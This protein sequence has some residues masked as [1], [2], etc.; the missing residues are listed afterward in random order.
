MTCQEFNHVLQDYLDGTL[1]AIVRADAERHLRHCANCRA[2]MLREEAVGDALRHSL[3]RVT[4][5]LSLPPDARRTIEQALKG[6]PS[7]LSLPS[8]WVR[9]W[10]WLAS[11]SVLSVGW[12]AAGLAVAVLVLG[13]L[14]YRPASKSSAPQAARGD[15]GETWVVD[16]PMQTQTRVF[17]QQNHTVVDMLVSSASAGYAHFPE[18]EEPS[19]KLQ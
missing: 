19:S 4:A 2:S 11:R 16:V 18:T 8:V 15:Q 1:D 7:N 6:T 17:R 9:G 13:I 12:G 3:E 14:F 5:G 10:K